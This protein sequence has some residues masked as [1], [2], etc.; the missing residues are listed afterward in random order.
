MLSVMQIFKIIFGVILSAFILTIL[1]RFSLSYEEI[2]ESSREVEI[3]M[4]LKKTIE[5]VYT[6]GISTDFDLGSED[7]V[8]FYSPPNLVTSV[9]DVNLDPVPTLFVPGE[10]IS[11]HR[12][13]YDLG[14]WK[15]Y[16]VHALP[17]MRIIFVP[18]GTSETVWKIAENITK[19]LPS[20]ENTDAKVRFGVGCNETGETQTYLFLNWE[21][22]YFIRT[23]LTYLFVEGYEFV[24]CK[25]IEGYRII[26]ISETPVDADFQVVPIDDDM[27]Y[28]YVRDIQE[29]SKTYLYKNPLDIVSILLGGSKLYD[30]ENE[31]FLKELSIASSLASRESS[32]LRIKA[33]NPD[34]NIIYSRFTQVLGS[35]KSEIEEGNYRN[36][37]D[38]KE[39]NK[40]I[41]ESSGIYQELEEMGC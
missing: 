26:T 40:R 31:R 37:D 9:T 16:F 1:L 27:G 34:C 33:R 12:G 20:T 25:P 38:M 11:I 8:N 17:E 21:R 19:Y 30:Y 2:G 22:D 18:L 3:L 41:R 7:L 6:T 24:Q 14:W 23:V 32:L 28:V 35:L 5:D 13:E 36:E 29:G 10:R 39:L 15:F 4:G